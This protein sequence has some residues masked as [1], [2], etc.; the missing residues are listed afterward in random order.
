MLAG[1]KNKEFNPGDFVYVSLSLTRYSYFSNKIT[2]GYGV[3]VDVGDYNEECPEYL[4]P[5]T[6]IGVLINGSINWYSPNEIFRIK[7]R[8]AG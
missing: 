3:I 6:L 4:L 8:D 5:S 2:A 7:P 1:L